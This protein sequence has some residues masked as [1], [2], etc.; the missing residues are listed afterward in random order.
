[1]PFEQRM[2]VFPV[3]VR[4]RVRAGRGD[5]KGDSGSAADRAPYRVGTWINDIPRDFSQDN[6][7]CFSTYLLRHSATHGL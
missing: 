5:G 3:G 2:Q 1:M 6:Q 4:E 7:I